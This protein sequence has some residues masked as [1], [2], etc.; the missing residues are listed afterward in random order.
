MDR[1]ADYSFEH[2]IGQGANG[3]YYLARPPKRLALDVEWVAVKV[4][5]TGA[6][7]ESLRKA[8]NELRHFVAAASVN[9]EYLVSLFDA[10]QDGDDFFYVMEYYDKGSL[11]TGADAMTPDERLTAVADAARGA[12]ALHEAGIVH[13]NIKPGNI[14]LRDSGAR[15]WPTS[16]CRTWCRRD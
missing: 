5:A 2:K 4:W 1:I 10:G 3:A 11:A 7:D 8:L 16:G 14:M 15:A 9:S 13:R 12:H 6:T